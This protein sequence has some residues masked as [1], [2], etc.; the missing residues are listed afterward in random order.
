[1]EKNKYIRTRLTM[2]SFLEFAIWGA[3]LTS[4]GNYLGNAG[5][6]NIIAWFFAIQGLV[7]LV[8]PAF[9]GFVG[10]KYIMP[11]R[12]LCLCQIIAGS[13]MLGCWYL[14][15]ESQMPNK[16]L[17]ILF[18]TLSTAFFMPTVALSNSVAFRL[19][20]ANG[21]DT[22]TAFPRIRVFGTIG[23]IM[24]MLF[25]NFAYLDNNHF[26]FSDTGTS[27]FQY[28]CWQFLT[29][30]VLSY[31]L[32]FY[33]LS[34]P[35][36]ALKPR[37]TNETVYKKLGLDALVIFRSVRIR[38]FFFFSI[39]LGMCLK[40]TNGYA[41]PFITSFLN[42]DQYSKG[43]GA[44][45]ANLLTSI[46]QCSEALCILLVPFFMRRFGMKVVFACAMFAWALRFGCFGLGNPGEGLWL[47]ILSMI[48]YGVAFDFFNISGAIFIEQETDKSITASAQG[49]WMMATMGIGASVGTLLAGAVVNHFCHWAPSATHPGM[50][51]LV[52]DWSTVWLIFSAFAFV[53]GIAFCLVF[54]NEKVTKTSI[55]DGPIVEEIEN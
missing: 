46:S 18:Y 42:D 25:V 23:F 4:M 32:A 48:V 9:I 51:Y 50:A 13:F 19:L 36:I 28:Q 16:F 26:G 38:L 14:G 37:N 21:L 45:N 10:D 34:L 27:R 54:G 7:C 12:L 2:M 53:T 8:M 22:V 1:M 11:Q 44:A 43:F 6:G 31:V 40:V 29:S 39:L 41:A 47:L 49:L 17:F 15:Y 20:R 33:A 30:A 35:K 55:T 52:G 24:A 5:M 3:Y